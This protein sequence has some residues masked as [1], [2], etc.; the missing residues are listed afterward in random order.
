MAG[1]TVMGTYLGTNAIDQLTRAQA[2]LELHL[3]T[4]PDGRCATCGGVEPCGARERLVSMFT[5][6]GRLPQRR[7]GVTKVGRRRIAATDGHSWFAARFTDRGSRRAW[8]R[9]ALRA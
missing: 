6:Y 9:G 7:P 2:E 3:V 4:R 1:S 8:R 5:R